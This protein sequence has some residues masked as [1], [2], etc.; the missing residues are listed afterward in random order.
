[1][2]QQETRASRGEVEDMPGVNGMDGNAELALWL[3]DSGKAFQ[4]EV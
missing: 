2:L 1:M 3:H 4:V